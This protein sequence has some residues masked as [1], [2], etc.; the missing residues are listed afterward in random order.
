MSSLSFSAAYTNRY[1]LKT[2]HTRPSPILSCESVKEQRPRR[3][4]L[5][6]MSGGWAHFRKVWIKPEVY[7]LIGSMVVAVGVCGAALTNKISQPGLIFSKSARKAGIQAQLE[8]IDEVKPLWSS[9]INYSSSIFDNSTEIRDN[10]RQPSVTTL[11]ESAAEVL[12][13]AEEAVEDAAE[14]VVE[15]VHAAADAIE[16]MHE[17]AEQRVEDAITE[18]V[19]AHAEEELLE[20]GAALAAQ[21]KKISPEP[22]SAAA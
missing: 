17:Q 12:Q 1:P 14:T 7:P 20:K 22:P 18:L 4:A 21:L 16:D 13:V 15:A 10:N 3:Q 2:P 11:A 8:G 9:S 6:T 5:C 19:V